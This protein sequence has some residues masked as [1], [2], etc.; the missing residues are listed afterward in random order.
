MQHQADIPWQHAVYTRS[1]TRESY[2]FSHASTKSVKKVFP[3]SLSI[4]CHCQSHGIYSKNLEELRSTPVLILVTGGWAV[5]VSIES[6][7][8]NNYSIDRLPIERYDHL[9]RIGQIDSAECAELTKAYRALKY[10]C[11]MASYEA[12]DTHTWELQSVVPML[13]DVVILPRLLEEKRLKTVMSSFC[14]ATRK[15][16]RDSLI[17][18]GEGKVREEAWCNC[19]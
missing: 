6:F 14:R 19:K 8:D 5:H 11:T 18:A 17:L 15:A 9:E 13:S 1:S 10:H 3:K 4:P 7:L 12:G 2:S 16:L